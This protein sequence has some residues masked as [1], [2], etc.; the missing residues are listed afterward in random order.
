MGM[1]QLPRIAVGTVQSDA[2]PQVMIWALISA[3]ERG[4][5]HVQAFSSQSRFPTRDASMPLTGQGLRD[6]AYTWTASVFLILAAW[7]KT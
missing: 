2:D 7:L 3:L 5:L 1:N 6:R 4:G